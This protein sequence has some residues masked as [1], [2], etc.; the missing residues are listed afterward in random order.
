MESKTM[1]ESKSSLRIAATT[2]NVGAAAAPAKISQ[3]AQLGDE[4]DVVVIGLQEVQNSAVGLFLD[5]GL[6]VDTWLATIAAS[7]PERRQFV[8]IAVEHMVGLLLCLYVRSDLASH[9]SELGRA[10]VPCGPLNAYNKG[11]VS[12]RLRLGDHS[13]CI[14]NA[15]LAAH[16]HM[17]SRRA[18]DYKHIVTSLRFT[19][20][21]E[22]T[23]ESHDYALVLGD[24]NYRVSVDY[25][26]AMD[27]IANGRHTDLLAHDQLLDAHKQ[28]EVLSGFSEHTITFRPTFKFDVGTDTYDS[29]KKK[30]VPSWTDRIFY[31]GKGVQV[32][33]YDSWFSLSQSDHKPV[34]C[35]LEIP[36]ARPLE[37]LTPKSTLTV[38]RR[39]LG[40]LT[41]LGVNV[42]ILVVGLLLLASQH[43]HT[44][45]VWLCSLLG[46][47]IR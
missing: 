14:V 33:R 9:V 47:S 5:N 24:L 36:L 41:P 22:A 37:L 16:T 32:V 12:I 28:K 20:V 18:V 30:R 15:H 21:P 13:L 23:L 46:I 2:W 42:A 3:L 29:S 45:M 11:A 6:V 31:K 40:T 27:K 25:A 19:E 17:A 10:M 39:E 35:L 44:V 7:L 8:L 1:L 34:Y 38:S 4:A 43:Y 26:T